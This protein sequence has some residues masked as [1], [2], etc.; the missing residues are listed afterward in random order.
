MKIVRKNEM[1]ITWNEK[2]NRYT[3]RAPG[4]PLCNQED[5]DFFRIMLDDGYY[6]DMTVPSHLQE[7]TVTREG[8]KTTITYPQLVDRAGRVFK[9]EFTVYI[10]ETEEEIRFS[11][12]IKNRDKV[13][14]NE[15]QLPFLDF[16]TVCD[17][18]HENDVLYRCKGMGERIFNPWSALESGHTEY[19]AADYWEIWSP[20]NY[21]KPSSMAWMGLQ[22]ADYFLYMGRHEH[23]DHTCVMN[24]GRNPRCTDPR[25]I[26]TICHFPLVQENE[27]LNTAQSVVRLAKGDWRDGSVAYRQWAESSWFSVR[28][29]KEWVKNFP[30]WQRIILRHQYG[31]VYWKYTDLVD[32]YEHSVKYGINTL[33]V[34]GWWKG[35]FDNGYPLYEADDA[36]GGEEE[37]KKAIDEIQR[38]GGNVIL[39]T[40]GVLMDIQS[41]FYKS[42]GKDVQM[43]DMDGNPHIDHY[44]FSNEGAALRVYGYKSFANAC[45]GTDEWKNM[46]LHNA[47]IKLAMKPKGIFFDQIGGH[48]CWLCFNENHKHGKRGDLEPH[49]R[50]ENFKAIDAL[51]EGDETL[52]TENTVDLFIPYMDYH[53]GC[54]F[55]NWYAKNAYPQ[56]YLN[57]FPETV[58][59][60]RFIH[61]ERNDYK[62]QLNYALLCGYRF[63]V[64]IYRGRKLEMNDVPNY[65][66]HVKKLIDFKEK[67]H[68]FFYPANFCMEE[69][70]EL[71][72]HVLMSEYVNQNDRLVMMLNTDRETTEVAFRNK[73]YV[74]PGWAVLVICGDETEIIEGVPGQIDQDQGK[75]TQSRLSAQFPFGGGT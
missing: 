19:R 54:D 7:G 35:R 41:D 59:T 25:L 53:H 37:L 48:K 66:K 21:P 47:K 70:P 49:Y 72:S 9:V 40:N 3:M 63:D 6:R 36:L 14:V 46:L 42:V 65:A 26:F 10:E 27:T 55:G 39:Y 15:V 5:A 24:V 52:G 61:D 58:V 71:P 73:E 31:E 45:N 51:L 29:K 32:I 69:L 30:G 62:L 16:S 68:R 2:G 33:N 18:N 11:S 8:N 43:Q 20:L 60:N 4:T 50:I 57:T 67:Y 75:M 56:L 12:Q 44:P 34:F 17:S 13:R 74:I 22:S 64:S 23:A 28:E 38:R 1:Q